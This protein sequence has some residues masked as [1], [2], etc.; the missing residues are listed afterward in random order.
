MT[1]Q[2][3][4]LPSM[5]GAWLMP[6]LPAIVASGTGSIV[7]SV[8]PNPQHAMWT[9]IFSYFL[10]GVGIPLA[11]SILVLLFWRLALFHVPPKEVVATVL[12]A[13]GPLGQ[14]GFAIQELGRVALNVFPVTGTLLGRSTGETLYSLGFIVALIMWGETSRHLLP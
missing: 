14:G 2:R 13:I 1:V 10:W 12:I 8:L 4:T 7:A 5:T 3:K 6:A 9:V 11:M